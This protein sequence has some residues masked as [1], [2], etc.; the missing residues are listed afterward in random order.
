MDIWL[1]ANKGYISLASSEQGLMN[2]VLGIIN[3]GSGK[4]KRANNND[5]LLNL[6]DGQRIGSLRIGRVPFSGQPVGAVACFAQDGLVQ[7]ILEASNGTG[8]SERFLMIVEN[9]NLGNRDH[10]KKRPEDKA[11]LAE[12]AEKCQFFRD[13]LINP[14]MYDDLVQLK[15]SDRAMTLIAM[16]KNKIEMHLADGGKFSHISLRGAAG[17]ADTQIIKIAANLQVLDDPS[18]GI[19]ADKYVEAAIGIFND[20]LEA[21]LKLCRDKD[22]IGHTAEYEAITAYL[23]RQH[24]NQALASAIINSMRNT[25]P[26]K[27]FTGSKSQ[28]I[29]DALSGMVGEGLLTVSKPIAGKGLTYKLI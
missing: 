19:V 10:M 13:V 1:K 23:S 3:S 6:F 24:S 12:Y 9:H 28:A 17:K 11:L 15:L 2:S 21:N 22:I 8:V 25:Q 20:L 4:D 29:N 5:T 7:T 14:L 16:Y 18:L 27:S 26:F